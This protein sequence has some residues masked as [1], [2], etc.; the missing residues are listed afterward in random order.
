MGKKQNGTEKDFKHK[1]GKILVGTINKKECT[2]IYIKLSTYITPKY[3]LFECVD[4][5]RKRIK[6]NSYLLNKT[7]FEDEYK[8]FLF[9]IQFNQTTSNDK[10]NKKSYIAI[11]FTIFA[12]NQFQFNSDLSFI[13]YNYADSIFSLLETFYDDFDI[14]PSKK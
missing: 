5:I 14:S 6:A 9:E 11:E 1:K 2:S 7:Y 12:K 4:K 3:S 8:D 10:P 13:G